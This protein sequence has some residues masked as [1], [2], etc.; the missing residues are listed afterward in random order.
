[1][2]GGT[3]SSPGQVEGIRRPQDVASQT[4]SEL[5]AKLGTRVSTGSA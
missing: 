2:R 3:E 4:G 1:M 5:V